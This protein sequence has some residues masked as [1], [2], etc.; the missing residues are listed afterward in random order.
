MT[1]PMRT[2]ERAAADP[3][4]V[5]R[6]TVCC[7]RL[8]LVLR[9]AAELATARP[10]VPL[11]VLTAELEQRQHR[12]D[13]L[14]AGGTSDGGPRGLLLVGSAPGSRDRPH[15]R[16]SLAA[17]H[18][19]PDLDALAPTTSARCTTSCERHPGD[20]D[21]HRPGTGLG[22]A[23][24]SLGPRP[25]PWGSFGRPSRPW[26]NPTSSESAAHWA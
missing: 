15:V 19:G 22:L 18:P 14:E 9:V 5:A 21:L 6:L 12:L 26:G 2:G 1:W 4:A 25:L 20:S 10:D 11:A 3:D 16:P 17:L 7:C 23:S 8:P 24:S 13:Q